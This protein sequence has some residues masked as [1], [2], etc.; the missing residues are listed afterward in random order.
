V[1]A[2][3]CRQFSAAVVLILI[4]G[5]VVLKQPSALME[6]WLSQVPQG[7]IG[8]PEELKAVSSLIAVNEVALLM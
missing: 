4:D 6:K 3:S 1:V 2:F 5:T 7:R 8:K